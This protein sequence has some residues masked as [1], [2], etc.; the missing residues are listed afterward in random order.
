MRPGLLAAKIAAVCSKLI[1][2][3]F[4]MDRNLRRIGRINGSEA[5]E[6]D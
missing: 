6:Q 2:I 1:S 4:E 5:V 3:F